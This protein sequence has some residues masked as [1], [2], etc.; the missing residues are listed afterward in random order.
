MDNP[1]RY[2]DLLARFVLNELNP[3]EEKEVIEWLYA[4]EENVQ[5]F[6]QFKELMNLSKSAS[7]LENVDVNNEWDYHRRVVTGGE[8]IMN[9]PEET[10]DFPFDTRIRRRKRTNLMLMSGMAA[11]FV[12]VI[13]AVLYV[14]GPKKASSEALTKNMVTAGSVNK[15][16]PADE[17]N[18]EV[19]L[20]D[21]PRSLLLS[22]GSEVVLYAN[23]EVSYKKEFTGSERHLQLK[24]K[25]DF[26]VTKDSA[27]PFIVSSG[28]IST[29]VLGTR[30]TVTAYD[31]SVVASVRLHEGKV[32]VKSTSTASKPLKKDYLLVPGQEL[33]YNKL[34]GEAFVR[35][36]KKEVIAKGEDAVEHI[37]MPE[38]FAGSWF[39]FNNQPLP[40]VLDQL[41]AIYNVEISYTRSDLEKMY[42]IGRFDQTDSISNILQKISLLYQLKVSNKNNKY[43]ISK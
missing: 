28:H 1:N 33:V 43:S 20:T 14:S 35:W 16:L 40:D 34:N 4:S 23:S 26:T 17:M 30:F 31:E 22:D 24:G 21:V 15:N 7:F 2:D 36:F 42:F 37:D 3:D 25:A 19:N 32:I 39:M 18:R 29:T 13:V 38:N 10:G 11:S 41:Q 6:E 5:Y 9:V 12:L 8:M 27:K